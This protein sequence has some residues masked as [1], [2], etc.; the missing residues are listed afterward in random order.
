MSMSGVSIDWM[1]RL[2]ADWTLQSLLM[3]IGKAGGLD[4]ALHR[5]VLANSCTES[6]CCSPVCRADASKN[7]VLWKAAA[8]TAR[9]ISEGLKARHRKACRISTSC[10]TCSNHPP[11][12][13]L[14][15]RISIIF[16]IG[17]E[18]A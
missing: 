7:S 4:E 16:S 2:N 5:L 3:D 12:A 9:T 8:I 13:R 18:P 15:V 6:I 14:L 1:L 17:T 10:S 11:S